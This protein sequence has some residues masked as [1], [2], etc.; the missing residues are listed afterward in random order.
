MVAADDLDVDGV[1]GAIG[2]VAGAA[3]SSS[4][5]DAMVFGCINFAKSG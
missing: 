3:E 1:S 2:S 4:H 5:L